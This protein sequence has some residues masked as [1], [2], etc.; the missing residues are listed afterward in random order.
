MST[1]V[2]TIEDVTVRYKGV[3]ALDRVSLSVNAAEI[4]AVLGENGA[5]K[6]TLLRFL[7]GLL[8]AGAWEGQLFVGGEPAVLRS[9]ADAIDRGIGVV[10][11]RPGLFP[12][13]T[14]ADNIVVGAW[15]RERSFIVNKQRVHDQAKHA[16]DMV[17]LKLDPSAL[18]RNLTPIQQRLLMIARACVQPPK[19]VVLDEP[20]FSLSTANELSQLFT[21]VRSLASR[22]VATLYLSRRPTEVLQIADRITVLRDGVVATEQVRVAFDEAS[23]VREMMSQRVGDGGYVDFDDLN[24]SKGGWLDGLRNLF[25]GNR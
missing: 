10:T 2:I 3:A 21:V 22:G 25:T 9:P 7:A 5:G 23:L 6:T 18:A 1:P 14:I 11:R 17:G 19:I 12:G 16:L 13:L 24:E 8:K 4:H 20:S 15:Q